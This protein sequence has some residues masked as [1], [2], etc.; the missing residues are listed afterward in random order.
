MRAV[1]RGLEKFRLNFFLW[2]MLYVVK[3]ALALLVTL[4][5][6]VLTGYM[7]ERSVFADPL[8]SNWTTSVLFELVRTQDKTAL[9][10][11]VVLLFIAVLAFLIKQFLNGGLYFAYMRSGKA[12][13]GEFWAEAAGGFRDHLVISLIMIPVYVL[14]LAIG[15]TLSGVIPTTLF[16]NFSG[17]ILLGRMLRW[18][19]LAAFLIA[20]VV[21]SESMRLHRTAMPDARWRDHVSG[22]L[23]FLQTS[24]VRMYAYYWLYFL[25]FL[26]I[27]LIIEWLAIQITGGLG[28]TFGVVAELFLFQICAFIRTG[29]SLLYTATAAPLLVRWRPGRFIARQTELAL[30]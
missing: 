30:G 27:W 29:Q 8:T 21:I 7:L 9:S 6:Y 20:A 15:S 22:A 16:G 10:L 17:D 28:N 5:L 4:P 23:A 18:L 19:V 13:G 25:P 11:G 1:T 3:L 26:V 14:F 24:G 2:P 12:P